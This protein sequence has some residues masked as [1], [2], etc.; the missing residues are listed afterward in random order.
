ME[1]NSCL[2]CDRSSTT[3]DIRHY[4]TLDGVY[5]LPFGTGRRFLHGGVSID[6]G[7]Q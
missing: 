7:N 5:Q 1:N 6:Q 4:I 2:A 3:F